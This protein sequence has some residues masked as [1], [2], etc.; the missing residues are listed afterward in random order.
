MYLDTWMIVTIIL[1]FGLCAYVSRNQ[2]FMRGATATLEALER[3]RIIKVLEDGQIKRWAPYNDV[4]A[5][6]VERKRK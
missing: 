6:K 3:E 2:G 5:K 4:P 1:S